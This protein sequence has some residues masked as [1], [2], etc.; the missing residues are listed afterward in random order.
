MYVCG[1]FFTNARQ[2]RGL[3]TCEVAAPAPDTQ[4]DG[5]YALQ[6]VAIHEDFLPWEWTTQVYS[7]AMQVVGPPS[8]QIACWTVGA[9]AQ[10]GERQAANAAAANA[11]ILIVSVCAA[12]E[13]PL[14]VH[15][16][17]DSWL[18]CRLQR[19]GAL[20]PVLGV[21][22]QPSPFPARVREY[23]HDVATLAHLDFLPH[24]RTLPEASSRFADEATAEADQRVQHVLNQGLRC[25]LGRPLAA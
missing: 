3:K 24:E 19:T 5:S 9:L 10:P 4:A 12:R 21:P 16:W 15:L 11:D 20:V 6:V 22:P 2:D 13:L 17:I 14:N 1:S 7:L 8:V 23:L 25:H 18:P